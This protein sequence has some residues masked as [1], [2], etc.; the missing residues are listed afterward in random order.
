MKMTVG[1]SG[2]M[3]GALSFKDPIGSLGLS[4]Y[5][6]G[7]FALKNAAYAMAAATIGGSLSGGASQGTFS[8]GDF[9]LAVPG[10]RLDALL[11]TTEKFAVSGGK[12]K[13]AKNAAVKV[14]NGGLVVDDSNGKTNRSSLKLTYTASTGFFKGS[15]KVYALVSANGRASLK[16][17]TV[18]VAGFVVNGEGCGQATCKKPAGGPWAVTVR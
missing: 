16:K 4:V 13:F 6:D 3:S 9:D 5:A 14:A 18:N 7:S 11:P 2:T 8:L 17:Y 1:Q 10:E 12:W 15:F